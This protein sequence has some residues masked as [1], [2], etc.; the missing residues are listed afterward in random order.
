MPPYE[1]RFE[2]FDVILSTSLIFCLVLGCFFV[3]GA[4]GLIYQVLWVRLIDKVIG[5]VLII[6]SAC[7]RQ[8]HPK[9][10]AWLAPAVMSHSA[11][12]SNGT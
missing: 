2:I 11:D 9:P 12:I 5:R 7:C 3:S 1:N 4:T 10:R 6:I 8:S